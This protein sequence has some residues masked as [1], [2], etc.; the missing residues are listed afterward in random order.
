MWAFGRCAKRPRV[1]I[2]REARLLRT[3]KQTTVALLILIM[4]KKTDTATNK[5]SAWWM[6]TS[7]SYEDGTAAPN[8]NNNDAKPSTNV[9]GDLNLD[10]SGGGLLDLVIDDFFCPRQLIGIGTSYS[11]SDNDQFK[12]LLPSYSSTTMTRSYDAVARD[13]NDNNNSSL[14][15][16]TV[17][18]VIRA[19]LLLSK[20]NFF[21][22]FF[23]ANNNK[24]DDSDDKLSDISSTSSCEDDDRDD[25]DEHGSSYSE[26][27]NDND[28]DD[29]DIIAQPPRTLGLIFFD[30]I[31]CLAVSA[32][33]RCINTQ[34][35]PLFIMTATSS[36]SSN[37]KP[38]HNMDMDILS[39]SLRICITLFA[40]VLILVEFPNLFPCL[41]HSQNDNNNSKQ[42]DG[43]K[44]ERRRQQQ[45]QQQSCNN[46]NNSTH[47]L[48]ENR[49]SSS[50]SSINSSSSTTSLLHRATVAETSISNKQQRYD[51]EMNRL[52]PPPAAA[53]AATIGEGDGDTK[54]ID[55]VV[56]DGEE[57]IGR[58]CRKVPVPPP[59]PP[60]KKVVNE[61]SLLLS[62]SYSTT[63]TTSTLS[64]KM[65]T[66]KKVVVNIIPPLYILNW[67][68]R[69]ILY[70]F[71]GLMTL[72][73]SIIVLA[74]DQSRHASISSRF[75]DGL[76]VLIS[77]YLMLGVG[78]MYVLF[79]SC[80]LQPIME[81][82]R[83]DD[84]VRWTKYYELVDEMEDELQ[85]VDDD[86]EEEREKVTCYCPSCY[87]RWW[88]GC[89][90]C[91]KQWNRT[92]L[93]F[94]FR[95]RPIK[96]KW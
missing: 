29:D 90:R 70:I 33:I 43:R 9:C 84:N 31:R 73:Q 86:D 69:G 68:P 2:R 58:H 96:C 3:N 77:G 55:V 82:V 18:N 91:K 19:S 74:Q 24:N 7:S 81:R 94:E 62:S 64:S 36:R 21:N 57:I 40:I 27:N 42:H 54:F 50:S 20:A 66:K 13:A 34:L 6:S 38:H 41:Q 51:A 39:I 63:R 1:E 78:C 37:I 45:Q 93:C 72:Q 85:Y 5:S 4:M 26:S 10:G 79:G 46:I 52:L 89:E 15:N 61:S 11:Q 32:N 48:S 65:K 14:G 95:C 59:P 35:M 67:I 92:G 71:L 8:N 47:Y 87:K 22:S 75:F 53:A 80:C 17:T 25:G 88:R 30:F 12:S 60:R 76:F 16:N 28:D 49:G 23:K 44:K 56:H 83:Y